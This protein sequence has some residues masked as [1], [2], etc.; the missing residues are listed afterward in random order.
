MADGVTFEILHRTND[1]LWCVA[2]SAVPFNFPVPVGS[3]FL[4]VNGHLLLCSAP[5]DVV[6]TW[7]RAF[8]A[9]ALTGLV[10]LRYILSAE[11]VRVDAMGG[12]VPTAPT[13]PTAAA[14]AAAATAAVVA[15]GAGGDVGQLPST[16]LK[17]LRQAVGQL[18]QLDNAKA[19]QHA[20][21]WVLWSDKY[22]TAQQLLL[23]EARARQATC[24]TAVALNE[25]LAKS[26]TAAW[27]DAAAK[28]PSLRKAAAAAMA[29]VD[30]LERTLTMQ[31]HTRAIYAAR[32][33]VPAKH[34][35]LDHWAQDLTAVNKVFPSH[36]YKALDRGQGERECNAFRLRRRAEQ[37]VAN[38]MTSFS[39]KKTLE[40]GGSDR[41][42]GVVMGDQGRGGQLLSVKRVTALVAKVCIVAHA[43]ED[44]STVLHLHCGGPTRC[45]AAGKTGTTQ[46]AKTIRASL[47][48]TDRNCV[49]RHRF[50]NRDVVAACNIG[51]LF[52]YSM[53]LG[54]YL[55]GFSRCEALT[56]DKT[57]LADPTMR[58]SLFKVFRP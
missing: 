8:Q 5:Q 39:L 35:S 10:K 51:C 34:Y 17:V 18:L 31:Q 52:W 21:G 23:E 47:Q 58:L 36:V 53:L 50:D 38:G 55:G 56:A 54:G 27:A 49:S 37:V 29:A 6:P 2:L 22:L 26:A 46:A 40:A 33:G 4:H 43:S 28:L 13:A 25:V 15:L 32:L 24:D 45:P 3:Q 30:A 41:P 12:D 42:P 20:S 44:R 11:V 7:N 14:T 16:H 48:C 57:Q 19:K 1:G 9:T